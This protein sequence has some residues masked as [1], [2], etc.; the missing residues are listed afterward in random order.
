MDLDFEQWKKLFETDP[1]AFEKKRNEA[2]EKCIA[3]AGLPEEQ[4][5]LRQWQWQVDMKIRKSKNL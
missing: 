4:K 1:K 5:K 3:N 2:I